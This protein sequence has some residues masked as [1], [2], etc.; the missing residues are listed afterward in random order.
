MSVLLPL[1][2]TTTAILVLLLVAIGTGIWGVHSVQRRFA[3][4]PSGASAADMTDEARIL[5][6]RCAAHGQP[7]IVRPMTVPAASVAAPSATLAALLVI[8]AEP[9]PPVAWVLFLHGNAG[10]LTNYR[11]HIVALMHRRVAVLAID[12]CGFGASTERGGYPTEEDMYW[13]ARC[14]YT[15]LVEKLLVAPQ[16]IIVHGYSIGC[17][18]ALHVAT[19]VPRAHGAH[20]RLLLEAPFLNFQSAVRHFMPLLGTALSPFLRHTTFDNASKAARLPAGA[21]VAIAHSRQDEI[22]SFADAKSLLDAMPDS[23][24]KQLFESDSVSHKGPHALDQALQ[25]LL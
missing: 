14:A 21:R 9:A 8:P 17:A 20:T 11:E 1:F 13:D 10:N 23:V 2:V 22:I 5:G 25:Y 4:A 6:A 7:V 12:Y 24:Q 15:Y 18:A 3:F 19:G 16:Q